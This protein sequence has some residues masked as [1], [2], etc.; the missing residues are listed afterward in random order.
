ML[1]ERLALRESAV[2]PENGDPILFDA[3]TLPAVLAGEGTDRFAI[4]AFLGYRGPMESLT[5]WS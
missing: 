1:L 4:S 5:T 2:K 3:R